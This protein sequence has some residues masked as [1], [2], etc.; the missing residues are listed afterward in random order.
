VEDTFLDR[1]SPLVR[2]IALLGIPVAGL[3]ALGF[4]TEIPHTILGKPNL[5]QAAGLV[6]SSTT[7]LALLFLLRASLEL[8]SA[9]HG[10]YRDVLD[11]LAMSHWHPAVIVAFIMLLVFPGAYYIH[12][13]RV[14]MW[15]IHTQGSK[16]LRSGDFQDELDRLAVAYQL[17]LTAGVPLLFCL[18]MLSR[19]KR[20]KKALL[21]WLL[22]P[23]LL[24][25]TLF[26]ALIVGVL[27]H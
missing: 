16:V 5:P 1:I 19:W 3:A 18:H 2:L 9:P 8:P 27:L 4:N 14:F 12:S 22:L 17:G 25:G 23:V 7:V 6:I 15:M 20:G 26:G 11:F 10:V 21:L 13:D 24:V